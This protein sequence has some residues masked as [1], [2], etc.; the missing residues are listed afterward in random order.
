[1][2][3]GYVNR[4]EVLEDAAVREFEEELGVSPTLAGLVGVYS[5]HEDPVVLVVYSGT[6]NAEPRPDNHEVTA[7]G[8]FAIDALPDLAFR[9]DRRI[10][11][12]WMRS[13]AG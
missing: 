6:I 12:D 10:I 3:A 4:G 7:V 1:L 11:D 9:H 5:A 8:R 2:P 13:Q